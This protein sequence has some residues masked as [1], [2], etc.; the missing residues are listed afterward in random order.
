M[1]PRQSLDTWSPVRPNRLWSMLAKLARR[2]SEGTADGDAQ[3]EAG[4]LRFFEIGSGCTTP[5]GSASTRALRAPLYA[6]L[7][8]A[9]VRFKYRCRRVCP[10]V[11]WPSQC[12]RRPGRVGPGGPAGRH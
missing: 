11:W 8:V 7:R 4:F 10:E 12:T 3:R 1:V 5:P 9:G 2:V 6:D